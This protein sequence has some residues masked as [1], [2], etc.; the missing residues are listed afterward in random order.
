[1]DGSIDLDA[2][3]GRIGY[4]GPRELTLDVLRALHLAHPCAIPF[5]SLDPLLG[6]PVLI[7]A[8]SLEAKLVRGRRGG[9][10]FEHNGVFLRVLRTLGFEVTPLAARVRWMTPAEAPPTPLSHMLLKLD[11]AGAS[12]ICDV[13][14]GGQSPTAPLRFE[15]GVAQET[16]HGVYR[17]MAVED[18]F[19]LQLRLPARWETMYRFTVQPRFAADY[20]VSNWFTSTHPQSRF[21]NNLIAARVVGERRLNLFNTELTAHEHD[22]ESSRR[23]LATAGEA[24]AVLASEFGIEVEL[25]DLE[26]VFPR[27]PPPTRS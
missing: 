2:Y 8:A 27:L 17:L 11:L 24:H 9:Y 4:S 13:G 22:A 18:A 10:C 6:R 5:E 1:M 19:D 3:F 16:P 12:F 15:S 7:D 23:V 20:E 25:A 14:F 26:R 21:T